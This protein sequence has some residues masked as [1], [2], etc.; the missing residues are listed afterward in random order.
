METRKAL[1]DRTAE[2]LRAA[3]IEGALPGGG[4]AFLACRGELRA[5]GKTA[6]S[7]DEQAAYRILASALEAPARLIIANA[8]ADVAQAMAGIEAAPP[9]YGYDVETDRVCDMAQAGVLDVAAVTRLALSSAVSAAAMALT[10]DALV[11]T[12]FGRQAANSH[13]D[14]PFCPKA[15]RTMNDETRP[16]RQRSTRLP[17]PPPIKQTASVL[18]PPSAGCCGRP[19]AARRSRM[20]T[21]RCGASESLATP[22]VAV[23]PAF[24]S[25]RTVFAGVNGAILRSLDG[26]ATWQYAALRTPPPVVTCLAVSPNYEEDGIAFAGALQDGVFRTADR[27]GRWASWNFGLIDLGVLCLALSPAFGRDDTLFAGTETGSSAVPTAVGRGVRWA[28]PPIL[29]RS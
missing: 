21:R 7:T 17:P 14:K 23:S 28:C 24:L 3:L 16:A 6:K 10:T 12:D 29:R 11:H 26:G 27:G 25:D 1:A 22:A 8:G 9:G 2:S 5:C 18:P 20:P 13:P 15:Q 4:A 19:I